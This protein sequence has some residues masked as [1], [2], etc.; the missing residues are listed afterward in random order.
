MD[1]KS[2]VF[3]TLPPQKLEA[4]DKSKEW[5]EQCV[6][7]VC[8][9]GNMR[10]PN[11]RTTT[12]EKQIKY[13]L[14]NSII[15]QNDF[16]YVLNP[17]G[18]KDNAIQN[19]PAKLRDINLIVNKVNLLKGEELNRPFNFTAI[20]IDGEVIIEKEKKKKEMLQQAA[21]Q[22]LAAELGI[23]L[24]PQTDPKTGQQ[25]PPPS[26]ADIDKYANYTMMDIREE[27]AN[28]LIKD[29]QMEQNLLFKFNEGWEHALI[30][31]EE[32][33]YIGIVNKKVVVRPCN[34]L[35]CEFNRNPNNPIIEEG[36]WFREDRWL[37]KGQIMDEFGEFLTDDQIEKIDNGQFG[38][39]FS[40]NQMFPGYAYGQD[41]IN[42]YESGFNRTSRF[43]SNHFLV[44]HVVW[45]SMKQ[46]GFLSYPNP[47]TG[48]M[49]E[50]I[51]DETFKLTPDMKKMGM[52]V[53]W[54]W[55]DEV[56]HGTKVGTDFYANIEPVPNQLRSMDNP[57][58]VV[59]PYVGRV[60]NSTNTKQ[61]SLVDLIKP[62]QYLYN[63]VW[64]RLEN[65]LAKAKGKKMV[66]DIAQIPKSQGID[67]EKWMYLFDNVGIA[68][69]NSFEEGSGKFQGE[70]SKFNQ[71]Q[72]IDMGL[73]QAVG[74][75]I[76]ILAKIE[77][78]IDRMI[79][80]TP[81]R[82]G[83]VHQSET[84]G[85]VERAVVNSTNI[86]EPWFYTHND[87]KKNVLTHILECAKL[88]YPKTKKLNFIANDFQRVSTTIDMDQFNDSD[89][90]IYI[91]DS[92]KEH[93]IFSKLEALA[94]QA[95]SAGAA[96]FSDII[97]MYKAGSVAELSALI[98]K[99]EQ[100]KQQSAQQS[101]QQKMQ[102]QQE[103]I[104]AQADEKDKERAFEAQENELDRETK[105][106][107]TVISAMGFDTDTAGT[108]TIEAVDYGNQVLKTMDLQNKQM[109][110]QRKHSLELQKMQH[111]SEENDKDRKVKK[112]EMKNKMEIEQLKARTALA[113]PVSGESKK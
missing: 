6:D 48:K 109:N 57:F 87:I 111:A 84:V 101:E 15:N 71:Q 21:Y 17:Y 34:P 96:T 50:G 79:G 43:N 59:L 78:T 112:E 63:I 25:I 54:K 19:Q 4:K 70:T 10:N 11:G 107:T 85:G 32:Y 60:Y 94:S 29:V 39:N 93:Q 77:S 66:M 20:G 13:D 108:G 68:F 9:M 95:I 16:N 105:I 91:T 40:S 22:Q 45:M 36:D 67:L 51:V 8:S 86:T 53:E 37:T 30:A 55:I 26:F 82:E 104:K 42:K 76:S 75:Y 41:D 89:Y 100:V 62:H 74:Q 69:I 73:S 98:K 46:I 58:K 65:E 31:A 88:A 33:Y 1:F 5:M 27:W 52:S 97:D 28:L 47:Q 35:Y 92:S 110:E 14:V 38:S 44:T 90:G 12:Q 56:W 99:S 81:Q 64:F 18:V 49:E 7:A 72:A 3:S 23:S 2:L 113:N 24:E 103:M 61:T 83:Q 106:R 102:M 80:V